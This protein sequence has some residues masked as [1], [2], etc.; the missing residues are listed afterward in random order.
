[1][2]SSCKTYNGSLGGAL[3]LSEVQDKTLTQR[4]KEVDIMSNEH[5]CP[6]CLEFYQ[7]ALQHTQELETM[8]GVRAVMLLFLSYPWSVY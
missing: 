8:Q 4:V 2:D 7:S 6:K 5:R 3:R 1:M